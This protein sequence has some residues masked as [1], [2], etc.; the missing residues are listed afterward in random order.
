PRASFRATM[1]DGFARLLPRG[2][3]LWVAIVALVLLL[4]GAALGAYLY[5]RNRTGN[6]YHPNARFIPQPTP[7]LPAKVPDRFSWPLY[8]YTR[9]PPRASPRGGLLRPPSRQQ[10]VR[11]GRALLDFPPVLEGESIFQLGDNGVLAAINKRNGHT[12]WSRRLGEL[13]AACP[14]VVK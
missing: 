4:A 7:T 10:W 6:V 5:E 9:N 12:F 14:A 11:P 3:W 8:G 1:S 13:S 2:R